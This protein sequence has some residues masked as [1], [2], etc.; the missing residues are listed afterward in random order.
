[1]NS[2]HTDAMNDG[3]TNPASFCTTDGTSSGQI[4][5]NHTSTVADDD[6]GFIRMS[7]QTYYQNPVALGGGPP[8]ATATATATV[9]AATYTSSATAA[10][11]S[12][13]PGQTVSITSMVTS[14]QAST[15]LV[16][17]EVY[18]PASTK[19]FQ[20]FWDNQAFSAGQTRT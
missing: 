15:V 12:V 10:P 19:V 3:T 1:G 9:P 16:D 7:G 20:Q 8:P 11:T 4:C 2:T 14:S 5:N 18:D 13:A 6:G 17:V